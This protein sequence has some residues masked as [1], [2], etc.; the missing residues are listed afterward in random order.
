MKNF[1]C[2]LIIFFPCYL[3][4]NSVSDV[5]CRVDG[6]NIIVTYYLSKKSNIVVK[7]SFD[8][9]KNFQKIE[10]GLSGD[11][12]YSISSG[13]KQIIWSVL[14]EYENLNGDVC[15]KIIPKEVEKTTYRNNYRN[16][17]F[18]R[19]YNKHGF[20][21]A[22]WFKVSAEFFTYWGFEC[23]MAS[24]RYSI[25]ELEWLNF[26]LFGNLLVD[27]EFI[28]S[29]EYYIAYD[30]ILRIH[31]PC[32]KEW[33]IYTAVAPTIYLTEYDSYYW[34]ESPTSYV[35][36]KT[37]L[38][39]RYYDPVK[40]YSVDFFIRYKYKYSFAFGISLRIPGFNKMIKN[41]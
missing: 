24:L 6:N 19:F 27:D 33:T 15:F 18:S 32:F 4:A 39:L 29:N 1:I 37:D 36:F 20:W 28:G 35:S 21:D 9:G 25:L 3:F 14:D 16:S 22:E 2:C 17:V 13:Y 8:G 41:R 11:V 34:Y 7:V 5:T 10:K 38:G 30:P 26:S 40:S 31:I 23:S 12:G